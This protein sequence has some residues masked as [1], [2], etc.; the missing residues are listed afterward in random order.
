MDKMRWKLRFFVERVRHSPAKAWALGA[1]C[2]LCTAAT[3]AV[4]I[5]L[6]VWGGIP[7]RGPQSEVSEAAVAGQFEMFVDNQVSDA[8]D[9]VMQVKKKY[10]IEDGQKKAPR[11]NPKCY[12]STT[13]PA[14]IRKV[15]DK[16]SELLDGQELYFDPDV[17]LFPGSEF[18]YYLDETIFTIT[19]KQLIDGCAYT[20]AEVKIAHPSQFRRFLAG[21][22][23]GS[24][25]Y[26]TTT[27]MAQSVNAVLASSGDFYSHRKAGILIYNHEVQRINNGILDT[28]YIDREGNMSF[29]RVNESMDMEQAQKFVED[30]DIMFSLAFGPVLV[31]DGEP[32]YTLGRYFVGEIRDK[33][34]RAALCQMD[35]LHYLLMNANHEDPYYNV[36]NLQKFQTHVLE[37]GCKQ[38]YTLD[39]GQ[40]AVIAL[41]GKMVNRVM[42]GFQR[43][44]SDII[45]F[46]TAI[47]NT[48]R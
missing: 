31:I 47:P 7:G 11:P 8:L 15:I 4:L 43:R 40:T 46:A 9:G 39:G 33:Y 10:W 30:K 35:K 13:D 44:I 18:E 34:P 25:K 27:E 37:T 22:Q 45:Y 20:Y 16:A 2:L 23:F 1:F 29:T 21:G 26:Y 3:A 38:A 12:G 48:K 19:W 36:P 32:V 5:F 41:N 24:D 28:C 17:E 42:F 14:R 6:F